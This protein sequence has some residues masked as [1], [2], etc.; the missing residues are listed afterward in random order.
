MICSKGKLVAE[1]CILDYCTLRPDQNQALPFSI[2]RGY[3]VVL[4]QHLQLKV[5]YLL[6]L[7]CHNKVPQTRWPKHRSLFSHTSGGWTFKIKVWQHSVSCETLV[8]RRLPSQVLTWP[9]SCA[10]AKRGLVQGEEVSLLIEPLI[11][12]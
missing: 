10:S 12:S 5:Y 4:P 2:R 7:G 8:C 3:Q 1:N 6:C 11:P 9:F